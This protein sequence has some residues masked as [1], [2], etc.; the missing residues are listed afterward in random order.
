[1]IRRLWRV[2]GTLVAVPLLI[3][4][5]LQVVVSMA[6]ERRTVERTFPADGLRLVEV[7]NNSGGR[8]ELIGTSD[9]T[10]HVVATIDDG[11]RATRN[12][13]RRDGDRLLLESS[14]GF[15]LAQ[16]CGTT[17]RIEV[18]TSVSVLIRND[19][20]SVK[21][22][23]IDGDV[24]INSDGGGIE[25]ARIGGVVHARSDAGAVT[26]VA[27][28]GGHVT[29]D[30]DAG[31]VS[32]DF[33]RAPTA[34]S[35]TSDAGSVEVLVPRDDATYRVTTDTDAGS[36]STEVRTDPTAERTIVAT[37]DAGSIDVRYRTS[38]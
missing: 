4:I 13:E 27:L 19:A 9:D 36:V 12:E 17:Y 7:H 15:L 22:S 11:L 23:D 21:V 29:A 20:G 31:R 26:G 33:D 14:C 10:V 5:G 1:M 8:I 38:G 25:L 32:L 6:H 2:G 30:S 37:S 18:P 28:T 34:V 16:R 24:D 35:A 3:L